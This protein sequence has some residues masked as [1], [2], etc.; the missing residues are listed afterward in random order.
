MNRPDRQPS[1]GRWQ[2]LKIVFLIT[3]FIFYSGY[4][5]LSQPEFVLCRGD[6]GHLAI[7]YANA[8]LHCV[9]DKYPAHRQESGII[10][11]SAEWHPDDCQDIPLFRTPAL[12]YLSTKE[13]QLV[14]LS[15]SMIYSTAQLNFPTVAN[16]NFQIKTVLFERRALVALETTVL[17]I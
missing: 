1:A 16:A 13:K 6:N 10:F 12:P 4:T 2:S 7:E 11:L 15:R 8:G 9:A 3:L 17:L 5:R 14:P